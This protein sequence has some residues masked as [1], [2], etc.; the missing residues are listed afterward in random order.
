MNT[1]I[2]AFAMI[3]VWM[4]LILLIASGA[5]KGADSNLSPLASPPDWGRLD[6]YQE[7]ISQEQFQNLIDTIFAPNRASLETISVNSEDARILTSWPSTESYYRLRFNNDPKANL[8]APKR[9]W[10]SKSELPNNTSDKPLR[11]LKVAIDPG[12]IG[13]RW[14]KME[15]RWFRVGDAP[16]VCEGELTLKVAFHIKPQLEDLGAKVTLIREKNEPVTPVNITDLYSAAR[17]FLIR[18]GVKQPQQNYFGPRDPKRFSTVRWQAERLYY[19]AS[20]IRER[21]RIVNEVVKPDL[22]LCLHFNAEAWGDPF[23]PQLNNQNHLHLIINGCY[24]REE[25]Q[26]DDV[27]FGMLKKLLNESWKTEIEA[28]DI[29]AE[30]LAEATGLPRYIYR[31]RN[32]IAVGKS[33]WVWARN[34]LANRLYEC[35]VIFLEPYVMNNKE[36]YTRIQAGDYSGELEVAGKKRKSIFREYADGVV[37]GVK[38]YYGNR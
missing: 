28:S 12:H 3:H 15:E 34:L 29:I 20:E 4:I 22:V 32:A 8:I 36:V 37:A 21:A 18:S 6:I 2:V 33:G 24:M 30:Y 35:P 16:P 10:R 5:A 11:G 9:Y 38:A 17:N 25:L 27:R 19:R 31:G 23:N 26:L 7:S 13:G 1:K 14:A